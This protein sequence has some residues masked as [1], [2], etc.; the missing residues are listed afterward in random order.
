[1]KYAIILGTIVI[2]GLGLFVALNT[3]EKSPIL[4]K[5]SI[6]L[7]EDA[8]KAVG[9]AKTLYIVVYD[10]NSERPMPFGAV[11]FLLDTPPQSSGKIFE[12]TLTKEKLQVMAT[13][14]GGS[15]TPPSQMRLKARLDQDGLGGMD[16]PGDIV[17]ELTQVAKGQKD[18]TIL[19]DTVK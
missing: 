14:M 16:Q 17:G 8:L 11:R 4:A 7:A 6:H 2:A 19:L 12:F 10:E 1:M 9:K 3:G 18:L 5:G 15:S 13:A